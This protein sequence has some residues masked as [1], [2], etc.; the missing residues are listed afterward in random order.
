VNTQA[1]ERAVEAISAL[2]DRGGGQ[3]NVP[4]GRCLTGPFNLTSHMT[5]FIAEGTEMLAI[6]VRLLASALV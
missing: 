6:T 2:A 5:V 4:H 1:F 3:L